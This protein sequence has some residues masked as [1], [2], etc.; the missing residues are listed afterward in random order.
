M[1]LAYMKKEMIAAFCLYSVMNIFLRLSICFHFRRALAT[2][3]E[4]RLFI[5]IAVVIV[6][7]GTTKFFRNL[8]FCGEDLGQTAYNMIHHRE[9][10]HKRSTDLHLLAA[11]CA[12][13]LVSD[14]VFVV[15]PMRH[16][17]K[18]RGRSISIEP[19]RDGKLTADRYE[20]K[21]Q[22]HSHYG[23]IFGSNVCAPPLLEIL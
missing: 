16:I 21:G 5:A 13:N 11:Q 23:S 20:S 4:R 22:S 12:L 9:T 15:M 18:S 2:V 17:Y 19:E 1:Q 3:W 10:C 8:F 14:V 6:L 7:L